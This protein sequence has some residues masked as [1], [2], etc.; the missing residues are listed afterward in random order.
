MVSDAKVLHTLRTDPLNNPFGGVRGPDITVAV[1][2][3]RLAD[4][5]KT[6]AE[7]KNGWVVAIIK[8]PKPEEEAVEALRVEEGILMGNGGFNAFPLMPTVADPSKEAIAA[9]IG[10][11]VDYRF[12]R[13]GYA[14]EIMSAV[15]EYGFG[16]LGCELMALETNFTNA[17]FRAM[18]KGMGIEETSV[19]DNEGE[20]NGEKEV[21]YLFDKE[22]WERAKVQMKA[23]GKWYL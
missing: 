20:G 1:Q 16:E 4:G 23:N 10:V 5:V 8:D 19:V 6:T 3:E 12:T 22:M 17:P 9:N 7:G 15:I 11:L 18:M 21:R 14:I 13:K 2:A